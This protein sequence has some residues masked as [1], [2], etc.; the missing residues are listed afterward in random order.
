MSHDEVE[1]RR[2][3]IF[4]LVR[5][6]LHATSDPPPGSVT[7][8]VGEPFGDVSTSTGDALTWAT[9]LGA[10]TRHMGSF[11][12]HGLV[13]AGHGTRLN[14][15]LPFRGALLVTPSGHRFVD[16][17]RYGYS[18]LGAIIRRL[19]ERRA[20]IW[21]SPSVH[22]D[23]M[24]SE[25]MRESEAAGAFALFDDL[26]AACSALGV[27]RD[28]LAATLATFNS[29]DS[30]TG[31][32]GPLTWPLYGAR[33]TSGILTTQGGLDVDV[34]GRVLDVHG[35]VIPGLYA[36]GGTAVGISGPDSRGYSSGNGLL[37]AMGLG[38][39]IGSALA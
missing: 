18:S 22:D 37:S 25:L 21:W 29:R 5:P 13:V 4:A 17:H 36:G 34:H 24:R 10:R 14:P 7:D 11:L 16:E 3:L 30:V 26:D 32:S 20:V 9:A 6:A 38:W 27:D 23:V 31:T 12:G 2:S 35:S 39:I 33:I 28:G 8:L 15:A 19:P 1:E